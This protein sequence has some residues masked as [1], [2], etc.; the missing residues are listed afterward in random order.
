MNMIHGKINILNVKTQIAHFSVSS[1]SEDC[2][3]IITVSDTHN[4][5]EYYI[6]P[7]L[8]RHKC[9]KNN[10]NRG[11]RTQFHSSMM[12]ADCEFNSEGMLRGGAGH[13]DTGKQD[14]KELHNCFSSSKR[15]FALKKR[16]IKV[17]LID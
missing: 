11:H 16:D 2:I 12:D 9:C 1:A 7:L 10:V 17:I 6:Y 14:W 5:F 8:H 4:Y 15:C 3:L 13:G